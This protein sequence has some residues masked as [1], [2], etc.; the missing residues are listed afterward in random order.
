MEMHRGD[1]ALR[2]Q[3]NSFFSI[4]FRVRNKLTLTPALSLRE[5]AGVRVGAGKSQNLGMIDYTGRGVDF[6]SWAKINIQTKQR[7][8]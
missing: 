2:T 8:R 7:I 3:G 6:E 4:K 5:R 1:S